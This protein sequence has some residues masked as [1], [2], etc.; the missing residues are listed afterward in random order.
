[1]TSEKP[2]MSEMTMLKRA[3]RELQRVLDTYKG[4]VE[5]L[6]FEYRNIQERLD[7][8]H[9]RMLHLESIIQDMLDRGF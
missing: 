8:I 1:M 7:N 5:H 6:R 3:F 4:E 2:K 9:T